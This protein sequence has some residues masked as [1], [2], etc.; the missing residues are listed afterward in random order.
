[1]KFLAPWLL[2]FGFGVVVFLV[3]LRL[4]RKEKAQRDISEAMRKAHD[5]HG[6]ASAT[7][8]IR[9]GRK[10]SET[11]RLGQYAAPEHET[12]LGNYN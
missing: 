8:A 9:T 6:L 3:G 4:Q 5:I 1:M 11:D 10:S 7:D 12:K 2:T